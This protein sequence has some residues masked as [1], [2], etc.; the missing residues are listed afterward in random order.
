MQLQVLVCLWDAA[1]QMS[2][3]SCKIVRSCLVG[4]KRGWAEK[5]KTWPYEAMFSGRPEPLHYFT[6][7]VVARVQGDAEEKDRGIFCP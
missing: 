2:F 5:Q 7:T 1:L 3:L 4:G 6:Q